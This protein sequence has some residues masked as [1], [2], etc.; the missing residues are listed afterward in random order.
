MYHSK[1]NGVIPRRPVPSF[2]TPSVRARE[3][4]FVCVQGCRHA[5]GIG[6]MIRSFSTEESQPK[7]GTRLEVH[8]WVDVTVCGFV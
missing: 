3:L 5:T 4:V 8:G 2:R 7:S 6:F 1:V